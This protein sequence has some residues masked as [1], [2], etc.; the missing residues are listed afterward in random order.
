MTTLTAFPAQKCTVLLVDDVSDSREM[1]A[2]F[3]RTSGYAVHEAGD[4]ADAVAIALEFRPDV[5]V[6]D[7][8]LP[9]IDGI[10]AIRRLAAH[11]DTAAIPIV[12]LSARTFPEDEARAREAG[13]AAFLAKPCTPEALAAAVRVVSER[14]DQ[15]FATVAPVV[16][17]TSAPVP[18]S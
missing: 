3:L 14:C 4:G 12:V 17:A 16:E 7:L 1:Y 5:V 9:G 15:A 8:S 13:A 18:A 6:M 11:A 2:F 10:T